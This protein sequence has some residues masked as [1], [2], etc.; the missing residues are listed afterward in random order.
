V[1][2]EVIVLDWKSV[3]EALT[4]VLEFPV[5]CMRLASPACALCEGHGGGRICRL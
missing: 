5:Q 2:A 3:K 1:W 4:L